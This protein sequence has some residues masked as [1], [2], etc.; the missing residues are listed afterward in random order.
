VCSSGLFVPVFRFSGSPPVV[1]LHDELVVGRQLVV[2]PMRRAAALRAAECHLGGPHSQL[3]GVW[4]SWLR[5]ARCA[6]SR[7][8][9]DPHLSGPCETRP[10]QAR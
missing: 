2:Q 3:A 5:A 6:R 8:W 7:D 1:V 9:V 10:P 4:R